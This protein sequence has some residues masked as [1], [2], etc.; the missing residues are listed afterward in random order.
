MRSHNYLSHIEEYIKQQ[1]HI[2]LEDLELQF[3]NTIGRVNNF[4]SIN[5]EIKIL[6]EGD[7]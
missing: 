6:E 4:K 3:R 7:S 2:T 1:S 5:E